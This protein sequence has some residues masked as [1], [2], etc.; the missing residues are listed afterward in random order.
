ML[1]KWNLQKAKMK[2]LP[3]DQTVL[4]RKKR[5]WETTLEPVQQVLGV[6]VLSSLDYST[7]KS[8]KMLP[9]HGKKL[10][11]GPLWAGCKESLKPVD[12]QCYM[13]C[14]T[15][16]TLN[17]E[18]GKKNWEVPTRYCHLKAQCWLWISTAGEEFKSLL[19]WSCPQADVGIITHINLCEK[20]GCLSTVL[21]CKTYGSDGWFYEPTTVRI[22]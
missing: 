21:S 19:L 10:R 13:A 6:Q 8:Q 22:I 12:C 5:S 11:L 14:R 17:F 2:Q 4:L 7:C 9:S 18:G 16:Y 1:Q 15:W 20:Q 3:T